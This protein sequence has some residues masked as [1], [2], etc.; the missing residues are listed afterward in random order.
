MKLVHGIYSRGENLQIRRLLFN[1]RARNIH[2]VLQRSKRPEEKALTVIGH[3]ERPL[4]I[5]N[6]RMILEMRS[7]SSKRL[8]YM[9]KSVFLVFGSHIEKDYIRVERLSYNPFRQNIRMIARSRARQFETLKGIIGHAGEG[10]SKQEALDILSRRRFSEE[11]VKCPSHLFWDIVATR[12]ARSDEE[13]VALKELAS[14]H[15]GIFFWSFFRKMNITTRGDLGRIVEFFMSRK[16]PMD[17]VLPDS[18]LELKYKAELSE[19][20]YEVGE[21]LFLNRKGRSKVIWVD[22]AI[23]PDQPS[24]VPEEEST[25]FPLP[26]TLGG[27]E[28]EFLRE[29]IENLGFSARV[30]N[31]FRRRRIET[32]GDLMAQSRESLLK[33]KGFGVKAL[34]EVEA[35]LSE[36]GLKLSGL[37]AFS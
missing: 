1:P 16:S 14:F 17:F 4:N 36:R 23:L 10:I 33:F 13:K 3:P 30:L 26:V 2:G 22:G 7:C 34:Q 21:A 37:G 15:S 11:T 8:D 6:A 19:D 25:V 18:G 24:E 12:I 35:A 27:Y 9:A 29:R 20:G 32:V 28:I 5:E 31:C